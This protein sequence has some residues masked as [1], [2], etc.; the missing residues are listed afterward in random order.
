[1][2]N[3]L[4]NSDS[5]KKELI[6][7]SYWT[8]VVT[9]RQLFRILNVGPFKDLII[10]QILN[11]LII[12]NGQSWNSCSDVRC[13][14]NTTAP[15]DLNFNMNSVI[16]GPNMCLFVWSCLIDLSLT[17]ITYSWLHWLLSVTC[18]TSFYT[19]IFGRKHRF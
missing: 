3:N 4:Y 10:E 16:S 9:W 7:W 17:C 2:V 11:F 18:F 5:G 15:L 19:N 6:I 1:M 13:D 12:S 8:L 14:S